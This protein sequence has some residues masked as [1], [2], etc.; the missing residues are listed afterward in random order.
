[1]LFLLPGFS[2]LSLLILPTFYLKKELEKLWEN[3]KDQTAEATTKCGLV[4][5]SPENALVSEV[6]IIVI[7]PVAPKF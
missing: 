6:G 5:E 3:Y 7:C 2:H 1:M 4:R